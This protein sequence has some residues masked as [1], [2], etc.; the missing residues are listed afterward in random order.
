MRYKII[1]PNIKS[2]KVS[3]LNILLSLRFSPRPV[4]RLT[5]FTGSD[6][7]M[8]SRQPVVKVIKLYVPL[9]SSQRKQYFC[10]KAK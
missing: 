7:L 4:V 5:C 8:E 1:C 3:Y 2:L 6:F 10:R 9:S